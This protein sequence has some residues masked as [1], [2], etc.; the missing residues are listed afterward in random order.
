MAI[1]GILADDHSF[2]R[3]AH[4]GERQRRVRLSHSTIVVF[5]QSGSFEGMSVLRNLMDKYTNQRP[6]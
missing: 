1:G 2:F 6:P 5:L 3:V 4:G